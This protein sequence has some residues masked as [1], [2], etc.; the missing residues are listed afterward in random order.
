MPEP[1]PFVQ[2]LPIPPVLEPGGRPDPAPDPSRL[3][4]FAEDPPVSFF[5]VHARSVLHRFHPDLPP[6]AAWGYDGR[7]PGPT[8]RVRRGEPY[9][10]RVWNDL[11]AGATGGVGRP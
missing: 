10:L 1:A 8:I 9:L 11:P 3:P 5:E 2:E 6:S 7:I 4:G